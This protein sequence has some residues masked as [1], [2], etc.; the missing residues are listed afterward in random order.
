M[1][2]HILVPLDGSALAETVLPHVEE[3]AK[4]SGAKVSLLQV[5]IVHTMPGADPTDDQVEAIDQANKYLEKV[6]EKLKQAGLTVEI[7]IRYG[8][9]AEEILDHAESNDIDLVAMCSH[10]QSGIGRWNLGGVTK[11]VVSHCVK[12]V[13]TIRARP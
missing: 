11:R 3:L 6:A 7:H 9:D 13:L 2:Q 12:P 10:G 8:H 5:V 1:Y 4:E